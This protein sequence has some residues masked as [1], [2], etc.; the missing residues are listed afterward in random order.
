MD[1]FKDLNF[2]MRSPENYNIIQI[3]WIVTFTPVHL[4]CM[5][6]W[7]WLTLRGLKGSAEYFNTEDN[8][9]HQSN[10]ITIVNHK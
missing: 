8:K 1:T 6:F 7:S 5:L 9:F 3:A 2:I 10:H 4:F